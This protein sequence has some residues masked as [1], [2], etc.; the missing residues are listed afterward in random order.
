[1][2]PL[3]S[4]LS[5][6]LKV[7]R[8]L[9]LGQTI[10]YA[11]YQA[12]K[13]SGYYR[14]AT[15]AGNYAPL[16]ATIHSPF[17]LPGREELKN[18]LGKQARS[19]IAEADEV[20]S[21]QVRLFSNPPV[22]LVLAPADTRWHW[23]HYESHPSSWGVEDIKFLWEPARFGW[24]F[25]LGRAY[26]LTGDEKYPAVFWRHFETFILANPPNRGPNWASAQE[27]ALRLMA[28]LFAARAFEE[29]ILSTPDRKAVL[30]G[31]VAA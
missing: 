22:P 5:L 30:A 23:T 25:P 10:S 14:L 31:A 21:G 27:V 28:L 12:G 26:G 4:H 11:I 29:S 1:M 17:V 9:G 3:L 24:V 15:P 6:S 13:R 8:E 20:V 18:F 7:V 16:R 19:V 2:S